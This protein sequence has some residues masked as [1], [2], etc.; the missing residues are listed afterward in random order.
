MSVMQMRSIRVSLMGAISAFL[1]LTGCTTLRIDTSA[2]PSYFL[3]EDTDAVAGIRVTE[4]GIAGLAASAIGGNGE[5]TEVLRRTERIILGIDSVDGGT[6][7][8]GTLYGRYP[9]WAIRSR[10]SRQKGWSRI[11][12]VVPYYLNAES[13]VELCPASREI[14]LISNGAMG[15][16]LADFDE[17]G[18]PSNPGVISPIPTET[19]EQAARKEGFAYI[20]DPGEILGTLAGGKQPVKR[21]ILHLEQTE[22]GGFEVGGIFTLDTEQQARAFTV[23]L[24]LLLLAESKRAEGIDLGQIIRNADIRPDGNEVLLSGFVV[25]RTAA[26]SYITAL[27]GRGKAGDQ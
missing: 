7:I 21:I 16:M 3:P 2:P 24:R 8:A 9:V 25:S 19:W 6:M 4:G 1:V 10:L 27:T 18:F 23:V 17:R 14:V 12:D 11:D 26:L 13:R 5:I 20:L 22:N 15:T